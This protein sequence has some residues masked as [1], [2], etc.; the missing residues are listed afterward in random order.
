MNPVASVTH[1][2]PS[3]GSTSRSR[4]EPSP[5]PRTRSPTAG[6]A[7]SRESATRQPESRALEPAGP[8][9]APQRGPPGTAGRDANRGCGL[10]ALAGERASLVEPHEA[11]AI[12]VR[13]P[14]ASVRGVYRDIGERPA[15]SETRPLA[16]R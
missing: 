1:A 12:L 3:T 6:A 10:T 9:G 8:G 5:P 14:H 16:P 15:G 11:R 13:R 7:S 4:R 2:G